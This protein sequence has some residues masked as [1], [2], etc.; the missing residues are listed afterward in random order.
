MVAVSLLELA[1]AT[2]LRADELREIESL[3]REKKQLI[4]EGPPG[5]GKTY[6]GEKFARYFTGNPLEGKAANSRLKV[7]QF[8]QSYGYEDF[9][10]GIRPETR[11]AKDGTKNL[12]YHV[13]PGVFKKFCDDARGELGAPT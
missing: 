2:N 11:E 8:H 4:L 1:V 10:Q 6:V 13:R 12:E 7:V 5:S 3:L 9:I